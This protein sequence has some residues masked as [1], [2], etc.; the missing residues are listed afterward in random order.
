[1]REIDTVLNKIMRVFE[2]INIKIIIMKIRS[3]RK[4]DYE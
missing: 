2:D 1:M 3:K 4:L